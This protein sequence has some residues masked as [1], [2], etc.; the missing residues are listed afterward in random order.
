MTQKDLFNHL[1]KVVSEKGIDNLTRAVNLMYDSSVN[2]SDINNEDKALIEYLNKNIT[3][4]FQ[5]TY[6]YQVN[7]ESRNEFRKMFTFDK[8]S[9]EAREISKDAKTQDLSIV[10]NKD[11]PFYNKKVVITG[12]FER[13]P[14]RNDLAEILKKLGTKNRSS[15]SKSMDILCVGSKDPGYTKIEKAK[16]FNKSGANILIMSEDE[17]YKILDSIQ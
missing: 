16:I 17:L 3:S 2:R 12:E 9:Y 6:E 13:Y 7:R 15:V 5:N 14:E 1:D 11:T 10:E 4:L 8:E